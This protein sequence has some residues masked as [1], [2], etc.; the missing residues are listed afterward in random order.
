LASCIKQG[1]NPKRT[2]ILCAWDGEEPGLLG[3]TEWV[4][5]HGDELQKRAV[6]YINSDGNDRGFFYAGGSHDLQHLINDVTR[7]I[8][9]PEKHISV[10]QRARLERIAHAPNAEER[11]EIRKSDDVRV[12]ALGDGS[13]YTAF[14]DHAGISALSI[15]YDG[16]DDG[17]STIRSMTIS[18]GTPSLWIPTSLTGARWHRLG[19]PRSCGWRMPT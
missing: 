12:H 7:D 16:E 5:T 8:Q 3:S 14:M 17:D 4:E 2:I 13:D 1:W 15:G 19:E 10:Q 6:A 9:D 18:T 11:A